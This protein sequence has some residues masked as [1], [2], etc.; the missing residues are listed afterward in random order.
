MLSPSTYSPPRSLHRS[1]RIFHCRKRC[2]RSSSDSLFMSSIAFAFTA[3]MDSNLVP[4]NTDLIS[5]NEKKSHGARS[6]AY[7]GCSNTVILCFVKN[8]LRDERFVLV[9]CLV[10][11]PWAVLPH[12]RSSY[13]PFTKVCQNL[14]VVD[15][16]NSLTFRHPIHA[17]NPS[18]VEKT[19]II[20]LNLDLLCHAFFCL[21]ELELFQCMDWCL[22][23]GSYW[24]NHDSSQVITFSKKFGSF[25]MFWRMSAQMFIQIFFCSGVRSLS[26]IFEH[27]FFMLK[28]LCKICRAAALSKSTNSATA[29]MLRRQFCRTI[30]LTFSMLASVFDVLGW[31]GRRSSPISSLPSPL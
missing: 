7:G 28:L 26:T 5:G 15:L 22:L 2:C 12:F 13:H 14:L 10:K 3:S 8:V 9:R 20:A 16:V 23:S 30:S 27:I 1:M 17:N 6:G 29:W 19:I 24:K 18:D 31:L 25:S 4:F 21:G 11:N